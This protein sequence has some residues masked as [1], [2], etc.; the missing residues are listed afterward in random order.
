MVR[1]GKL[2]SETYI[3]VFIEAIVKEESDEIVSA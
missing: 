2:S 1:D 3:K